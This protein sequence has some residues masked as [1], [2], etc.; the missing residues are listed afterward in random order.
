MTVLV[1]I[2]ALAAVLYCVYKLGVKP[3]DIAAQ[4]P[5][6]STSPDEA[7]A[8]EATVAPSG[9]PEQPLTG[10]KSEYMYTF[11][12]LGFDDGNGNT[13]TMM[14]VNFD[15]V[16]Y[17]LNVVNIPRDTLVNVS[18]YT[19]KANSLYAGGDGIDGVV[20]GLRD[21]LGFDVDFYI[22]VDLDAF[23]VL[24]DAVGGIDFD[25]PRNMD[26]D[27]P[28]Q[29]LHIH[30]Q[31]GPQHLDGDE[32][33]GLVRFRKGNGG[34]GYASGDIGRI[35]MQQRFLT[36]ALSQIIQ[37][38]D[39]L[40]VAALAKIFINYVETDLTA[41]ELVWLGKEFYKMDGENISFQTI[42][43]N[44]NDYVN[45]DSYVTIYLNQWLELLN[46]KINPF[47][48]DIT[49][50]NLSIF[51]RD[52][53]GNLYVTD[54]NYAGSSSW[55]TGSSASSSGSTSGSSSSSPSPSPSEDVSPSPSEDVSPSPSEDV[56][57][58]PSEDVS[59]SPS[60]DVSP[61]PSEDVSPSPSEDVSPS[62]S[63]DVS[64]SPSAD[65][66]PSPSPSPSPDAGGTSGTAITDG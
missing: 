5:N 27:D 36:E 18:W 60:E 62:P 57:P 20:D 48:E 1:V 3:P 65:A 35:E 25:V 50:E 10:R 13:D 22:I 28:D 8:G 40:N 34:T 15:A 31:A 53:N 21:I 26:Y 24:V 66:S 46:E 61:S 11:V 14:V 54:G 33:L 41:G 9:D 29:N 37:K 7:V 55:G 63:E 4:A 58:S 39:E 32:A 59:P 52:A 49:A 2:V 44:T 47:K 64:P 6:V 16:N 19:K 56:S 51:T 45:G 42:P 43:A 38:Q 30:L 17:T 12:V 23:A